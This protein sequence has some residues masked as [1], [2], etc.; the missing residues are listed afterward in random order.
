MKPLVVHPNLEKLKYTKAQQKGLQAYLFQETHD[1][2]ASRSPQDELWRD[3][4]RMYEGVPKH[5]VRNTP[6]VN[7]PNI[8][9]TLGATA[10]DMIYAQAIDL[11]FNANPPLTVRPTNAANVQTAKSM[12]AWCNWLAENEIELRQCAEHSLLDD[13][14]LGTGIIYCPYVMREKKTK[15]RRITMQGSVMRAVAPENFVVPGGAEEMVDD[16]PWCAIKGYFTPEELKARADEFGWDTTEA[17]PI[18]SLSWVRSKREALGRTVSTAVAKSKLYEVWDIYCYYDIDG[19]GIPEDLLVTWDQGSRTILKIQYNPYDRR[20]FVIYRYQVR[21]HLFYGIGV[22]E[23]IKPFQEGATELYNHWLINLMISNA[24][25]WAAK[26]GVVSESTEIWPNKVIPVTSKDDLVGIQ[27]GD[28]YPSAPQAVITTL[29]FGQNR[30]GVSDLSSAGPQRLLGSRTPGITALSGLQQMNKRFTPA[31]DGMRYG[32]A[33]GVM[34]CLY[35]YAERVLAGDP[36]VRQKI[37]KILG[38]E[39]G[40]NVIA[41]LSDPDFDRN[42]V[43][44]LTACSASVN[45]DADKQNAMMLLNLLD[46]YYTKIGQLA[47]LVANPMLPQPVRDVIEKVASSMNEALD[48]TIRTFEQ[49]RDP[50][51]FLVDMAAEIEQLGQQSQLEQMLAQAIQMAGAGGQQQGGQG[52][53]QG[54]QQGQGPGA[55]GAFV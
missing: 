31:F 37:L 3:L 48:R 41:T 54:G 2:M 47:I 29:Q 50:Q 20:P 24:R 16:L 53:Q 6:I 45:R 34:Q 26:D 22:M 10:S 35:R 9:V 7:A 28:T 14:K 38:P 49:I 36:L 32:I 43:V 40:A 39:D 13:I 8:E 51:T 5:P 12:Q 42:Y 15:I 18:G 21:E 4:L 11:I 33:N 1:A 44:E 25:V 55:G 17:K 52:G 19:D 27:M 30:T 23:M 46:R